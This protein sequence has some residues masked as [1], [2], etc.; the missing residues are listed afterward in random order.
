[1]VKQPPI[2]VMCWAS[3]SGR[4]P[5]KEWIADLDDAAFKRVDKLIGLLKNLGRELRPP[6]CRFLGDAL[7]E[8]R[9]ILQ[10]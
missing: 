1:M 5:V 2:N 6:H 8:L 7:F 10:G 3:S 9:G 4:K